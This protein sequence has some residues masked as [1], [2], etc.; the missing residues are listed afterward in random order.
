MIFY[1][2]KPLGPDK[3]QK[4]GQ[5]DEAF[6]AELTLLRTRRAY[7]RAHGGGFVTSRS[8]WTGRT[9]GRPEKWCARRDSNSRPIAPEAIALSI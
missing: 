1:V 5:L 9:D 3:D 2:S 8:E 6:G 7:A 4:A